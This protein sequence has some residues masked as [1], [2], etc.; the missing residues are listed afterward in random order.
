[1]LVLTPG[2]E[3]REVG[4]VREGVDDR[5]GQGA[6]GAHED[7]E[8]RGPARRRAPVLPQRETDRG[9]QSGARPVWP[10]AGGDERAA[11]VPAGG[12]AQG[13]G[14]Q[15]DRRDRHEDVGEGPWVAE[16]RRLVVPAVR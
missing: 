9:D 10:R 4:V 12:E 3:G 1:D 6:V 14:E 15:D 16:G 7:R 11:D 2:E 5:L 13:E 8:E